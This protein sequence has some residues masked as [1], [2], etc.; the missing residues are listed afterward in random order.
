MREVRRMRRA[1][2][3]LVVITNVPLVAMAGLASRMF[4]LREKRTASEVA[5]LP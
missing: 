3:V 4:G 1:L 2:S 5:K